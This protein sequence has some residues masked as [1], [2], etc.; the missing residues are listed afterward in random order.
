[1][2]HFNYGLI[3]ICSGITF[4]D[5]IYIPLPKE[6]HPISPYIV[7]VLLLALLGWSY[8]SSHQDPKVNFHKIV[9]SYSLMCAGF[10]GLL[11]PFCMLVFW[12]TSEVNASAVVPDYGQ[13]AIIQFFGGCVFGLIGSF[14]FRKLRQLYART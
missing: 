11:A 10:I 2:R 6:T 9:L 14:S 7:P 13:A 1:M 12:L 8:L 3:A 5:F 4:L